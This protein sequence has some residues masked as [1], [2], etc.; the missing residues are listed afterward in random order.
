MLNTYVTGRALRL[1][2]RDTQKRYLSETRSNRV[3]LR[4][5][6]KEDAH[7]RLCSD[8]V[9]GVM[10]WVLGATTSEF[11]RKSELACVTHPSGY[12]CAK[13]RHN[14]S[15]APSWVFD[16][17][18]F[19]PPDVLRD[20]P[21]LNPIAT[22][23]VWVFFDAY[24]AVDDLWHGPPTSSATYVRRDRV[25]LS[26]FDAPDAFIVFL[27]HDDIRRAADIVR[28]YVTQ[29]LESILQSSDHIMTVANEIVSNTASTRIDRQ[30]VL[31]ALD[32]AGTLV[33]TYYDAPCPFPVLM[34]GQTH[35]PLS[36]H[37]AVK[38]R[39]HTPKYVR[40]VDYIPI[41]GSYEADTVLGSKHLNS[42]SSDKNS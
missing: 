36:A 12:I 26:E 14:T 9:Y 15:L 34:E 37:E 24:F 30:T 32:G 22:D 19:T 20:F 25:T 4:G 39:A 8:P 16:V 3:L 29:A 11:E 33:T 7:L 6:S 17:V 40:T 41:I 5:I 13:Q 35:V 23:V 38:G 1:R 27:H 42:V 18:G 10:P 2:P 31:N 28:H 21:D